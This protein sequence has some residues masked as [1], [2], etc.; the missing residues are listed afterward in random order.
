[1][2]K[3]FFLFCLSL[4]AFSIAEAQQTPADSTLQ[5]YVGTYKFSEGSVIAEVTV[6]LDNGAL[7]MTSSAGV[8]SLEKQEE[9]LYTIV[10]FQ[11]TAKFNRD[12]NKKIT[13]VTINARGYLLEGS[14]VGSTIAFNKNI[15][16]TALLL[17]RVRG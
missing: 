14:K 12:A 17:L 1:M 4:G 3:W 11:G 8:S 15:K 9:D 16:D 13:G 5:Q 7:T 2:K 10:T 6:A